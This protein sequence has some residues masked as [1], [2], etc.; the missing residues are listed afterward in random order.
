[1]T[2]S[3][4]EKIIGVESR[5]QGIQV[6]PEPEIESEDKQKQLDI[7]EFEFGLNLDSKCDTVDHLEQ[8][9]DDN[10][11]EEPPIDQDQIDLDNRV[12]FHRMVDIFVQSTIDYRDF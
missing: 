8:N 5:N 4:E 3:F 9:G 12:S 6:Y 7:Y 11:E 2:S 10:G 1:M